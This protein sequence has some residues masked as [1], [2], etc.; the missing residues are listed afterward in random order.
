MK[1]KP[2]AKPAAE[3]E[4]AKRDT[5]GGRAGA[6]GSRRPGS[7]ERHRR[8][9]QAHQEPTCV[10]TRQGRRGNRRAAP[11]GRQG[12]D[13]P[14]PIS[15]KALLK[16]ASTKIEK[17]G[18]FDEAG[19]GHPASV[20]GA[21]SPSRPRRPNCKKSNLRPGRSRRRGP[22]PASRTPIPGQAGTRGK[23]RRRSS[24]VSQR[25]MT[26]PFSGEPEHGLR[27]SS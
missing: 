2:A 15:W 22:K 9:H 1:D 25:R 13:Q 19:S 3:I 4:L 27:T 20:Q 12:V 24:P 26:P 17:S 16:T 6:S 10:A 8:D 7:R 23:P 5:E 21:G 14:P 18:L 11:Q